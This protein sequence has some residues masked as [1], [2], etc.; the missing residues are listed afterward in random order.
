MKTIY[1]SRISWGLVALIALVLLPVYALMIYLSVWIG[2]TLLVI[3]TAFIVDT[4]VNTRYIIDH[5]TLW[6]QSGLFDKRQFDIDRITEIARTT[7]LESASAASLNRIR[8]R[9]DKRQT[10]I[11]S[12]RQQ[13]AFID[14]LLRINPRIVVKP[15]LS[16]SVKQV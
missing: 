1:R 5:K 12:P 3:L 4:L 14:H 6:V 13:Q 10:L 16:T 7:S 11:L 8:L 2:L 15:P 9:L